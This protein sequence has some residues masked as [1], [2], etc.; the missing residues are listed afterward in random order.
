MEK[1]I[2]GKDI[3]KD[4]ILREATLI[5]QFGSGALSGYSLA[6][7]FEA[8][9]I[10]LEHERQVFLDIQRLCAPKICME[11]KTVKN[12]NYRNPYLPRNWEYPPEQPTRVITVEVERYRF[13][14]S[15]EREWVPWEKLLQIL[16]TAG[17]EDRWPVVEIPTLQLNAIEAGWNADRVRDIAFSAYFK[18]DYVRP[19][20][21]NQPA[22]QPTTGSIHS[23]GEHLFP[24]PERVK[25]SSW[26]EIEPV[27]EMNRKT[28]AKAEKSTKMRAVIHH[29][30]NRVWAFKDEVLELKNRYGTYKERKE[31]ENKTSNMMK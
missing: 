8:Q 28:I 14:R 12:P 25:L 27:A 5:M 4:G 10:D 7:N 31:R 26:K 30:G 13:S 29:E 1:W 24:E 19:I 11:T 6:D 3:V 21:H 23:T 18:E 16:S 15:V 17:H 2:T 22:Q 9:L 20:S